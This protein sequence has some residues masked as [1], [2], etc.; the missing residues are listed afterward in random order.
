MSGDD[1]M[2]LTYQCPYTTGDKPPVIYCQ[3]AQIKFLSNANLR[4]FARMFCAN[5][6]EWSKCPL[7]LALDA[8]M[9]ECGK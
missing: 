7:K 9:S 8:Q 3:M 5:K 6:T 1:N 2:G 4:T